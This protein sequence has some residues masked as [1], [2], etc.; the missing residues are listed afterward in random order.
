MSSSY[1]IWEFKK[2]E[3]QNVERTWPFHESK[4]KRKRRRQKRKEEEE[5]E[6]NDS[7][8]WHLHTNSLPQVSIHTMFPASDPRYKC[9]QLEIWHSS[10]ISQNSLILVPSAISVWLALEIPVSS[11]H[12]QNL[13]VGEFRGHVVQLLDR[14]L[15]PLYTIVPSVE[16]ASYSVDLSLIFFLSW[17]H[18]LFLQK[19]YF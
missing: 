6:E 7:W 1:F 4:W 15:N 5:E 8:P 11:L 18:R 12:S 3:T 16:L 19:N 13:R 10:L 2:E 9:N 14:C 17:A